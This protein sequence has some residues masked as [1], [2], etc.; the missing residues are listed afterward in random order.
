M[1]VFNDMLYWSDA[2]KRVVQAA[3]KISGKNHQVVLKRPRQPFAVKVRSDVELKHV[4]KWG[5][6]MYN[7]WILSCVKCSY[8]AIPLCLKIFILFFGV[9]SN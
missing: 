2:K 3:H 7:F 6:I 9:G 5:G 1:A 4:R 8:K